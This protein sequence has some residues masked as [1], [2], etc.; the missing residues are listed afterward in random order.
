MAH[1][2]KRKGFKPPELDI[3]L[4][5]GDDSDQEFTGESV[6]VLFCDSKSKYFKPLNSQIDSRR[7]S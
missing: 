4:P 7:G 1:K 6:Q 2:I 5:L 3:E